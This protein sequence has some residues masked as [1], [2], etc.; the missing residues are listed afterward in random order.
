M[1]TNA[2]QYHHYALNRI[3]HS[4]KCQK[5]D[6]KP[7]HALN[8]IKQLM[9][10]IQQTDDYLFS[11]N[12]GERGIKHIATSLLARAVI[13]TLAN[14]MEH[15]AR[16]YP[17]YTFNPYLNIFAR[18]AAK[19]GLIEKVQRH[20]ALSI[21]GG[22]YT[23]DQAYSIFVDMADAIEDFIYQIKQEMSSTG[24]KT[25]M[26]NAERVSRQNYERLRLYINN[27]FNRHSRLLVLR[28]DLTYQ[29]ETTWLEQDWKTRYW[30]AKQDLKRFLD[31]MDSNDLFEHVVGYAW[32]LECGPDKGWH[33]HVLFFCNGSKVREDENLGMLIGKYWKKLTQ[34]RGDYHNCNGYKSRYESLCIGMI[35]YYDL[36]L[37]DALK[38]AAKYLVKVDH[39]AR[40]LV[41]GN[42][43]TFGR[44]EILPPRTGTVGRP[45]SF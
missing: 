5:Q 6:Q 12:E 7:I 20:E 31:N 41:Q 42:G 27:L 10:I 3:I 34:Y 8:H 19:D 14:C 24:F 43:R 4:I 36:H 28:V 40:A 26:Y 16:Y 45:R 37:I 30:E 44:G 38:S 15:V 23:N 11:V 1:T 2:N 33:Y 9:P 39:I 18:H 35:N 21:Q 32:K 25:L 29:W 17:L 13:V 22:V